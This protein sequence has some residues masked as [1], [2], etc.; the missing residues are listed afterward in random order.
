MSFIGLDIFSG[1]DQDILVEVSNI[2]NR[3]DWYKP[4]SLPT[5]SG[6]EQ[7]LYFSPAPRLSRGSEKG[8]VYGTKVLWA[9]IDKPHPA[10]ATLPPSAIVW[11]GGGF[12]YYWLL[13]EWITDP[14]KIEA[15]NRILMEDVDGDSCWNVNRVLRVPGTLNS[16]Y[17]TN[18]TFEKCELRQKYPYVYELKDFAVLSKIDAKTRHKIRT[19]DRRGYKSRSERDWVIIE[20]LLACG[21]PERLI[22]H[23]FETQPCGD[24]FR[25]PKTNAEEYIKHTIE[26]VGSKSVSLRIAKRQLGEIREGEDGYYAERARGTIRLSTFV[27]KPTLL[28][29]GDEDAIVGDV[30]ASGF[31]WKDVTLPRSAFNDR[32]SLDKH[33]KTTAW[34]WLGRDDDVRALLPFIL[35]QLQD[36][37]L[38]RS[39]STTTLGRHG[40]LFVLRRQTLDGQIVYE[41]KDSPLVY[42]ETG[43]EAPTVRVTQVDSKP[44]LSKLALINEP[45]VVWPILGWFMASP[46]KPLFERAK[47][48]FPILNVY[49]TRGSGKTSIIRV[50]QRLLGYETP[51]AYDCNTTAFVALAL[52][53][54]SNAVPVAFSEYRASSQGAERFLRFVLLAYDTGHNPRGRSDQTTVDYPLSAPF[55]V[56]GEDIINDSAAKE[57]IIAVSLHPETVAEGTP[58]FDAFKDLNASALEDFTLGYLQYTIGADHSKLL[59]SAI[60]SV[61]AAFPSALPDRVRNNLTVAATGIFSYCEYTKTPVPNIKEALE[62]CLKS[63]WSQSMGRT[64]TLADEFCEFIVN[65]VAQQRGGFMHYMESQS[66]LRFQLS[67]AFDYWRRH[68]RMGGIQTLEREAIKAQLEERFVN[69]DLKGQYVIKPKVE[70][71]AWFYAIDLSLAFES[72]LDVPSEIDRSTLTLDF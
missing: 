21:A 20:T 48:R 23:I 67:T 69:G 71:N 1:A 3:R 49:G 35:R 42:L 5:I 2:P 26:Q 44:D 51:T 52:L 29:E 41:G 34:V 54:S 33:L 4:D 7:D 9:D 72:G 28:L 31:T 60:E 61:A 50:M 57:R 70:R 14:Q 58:A 46:Y 25:D 45:K 66:V 10:L 68:R 6:S 8:D 19:G 17:P 64:P 65:S 24:K 18:G 40:D 47:L 43:R 32:K 62:G 59:A 30:V 36:R 12:H 39:K 38:P 53:G 16:K 63:V 27:V 56:D 37:G 15:G 22:R 55:S 13:D 11:S